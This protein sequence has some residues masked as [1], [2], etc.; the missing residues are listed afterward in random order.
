MRIYRVENKQG[1]GPYTSS[2]LDDP[3]LGEMLN[4]HNEDLGQFPCRTEDFGIYIDSTL[5]FG[6]DSIA[7]TI[8]WFGGHFDALTEAGYH[9]SEYEV[10]DGSVL[11]GKSGRQVVFPLHDADRVRSMPMKK[12]LDFV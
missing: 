4:K 6:F 7:A 9:V 11:V 3:I 1:T 10:D 5:H 8:R 2:Y 12:L